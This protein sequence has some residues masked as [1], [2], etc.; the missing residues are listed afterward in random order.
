[1][2][3]SMP[4]VWT[5]V[6]RY[7]YASRRDLSKVFD[8]TYWPLIDIF[9]TGFLGVSLVPDSHSSMIVALL[10]ALVV[11]QIAARTNMEISRNVL[12]ELWDNNLVNWL[13]TPLSVGEWLIGLMVAGLLSSII[14]FIFGAGAVYLIYGVSVFNVG[15]S[16]VLSLF[17]LAMGGWILGL[18]GSSFLIRWGQ[19]VETMVWAMNWLPAPFCGVFYSVE[20][21]P[22]WAQVLSKI[23]P[24]TYAF[25]ALRGAIQMGE[26]SYAT[27]GVSF[28]LNAIYLIAALLLFYRM[29]S[30]S[31]RRGLGNL[32]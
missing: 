24:M 11:W 29:L 5:V 32:V 1:M 23:L 4:R 6:L 2:M 27:L 13:A 14:T 21:L 12:Q 15:P 17:S 20:I 10:T 26:I 30:I 9:M 22:G 7:F 18:I 16:I 31:K 3:I 28:L 8:F 19:R 25:K